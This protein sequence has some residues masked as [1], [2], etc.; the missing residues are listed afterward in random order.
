MTLMRLDRMSDEQ[1]AGLIDD[2]YRDIVN[3]ERLRKPPAPTYAKS[4]T[5][6]ARWG[7]PVV[8]IVRE[9][10]PPLKFWCGDLATS[11]RA[12]YAISASKPAG[13]K[14]KACHSRYPKARN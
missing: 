1:I 4:L 13:R 11:A 3:L 5:G 9:A 8:H 12:R 10:G 7:G 2:H 6:M 14:C